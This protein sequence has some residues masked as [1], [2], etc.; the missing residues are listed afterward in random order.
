MYRLLISLSIL[1][2]VSAALTEADTTCNTYNLYPV[3]LGNIN[4]DTRFDVLDLFE[5]TASSPSLTYIAVGARSK[6]QTIC[7]QG[8]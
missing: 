1:K 7:P 3:G 6:D 2:S 4:G 5:D 8:N